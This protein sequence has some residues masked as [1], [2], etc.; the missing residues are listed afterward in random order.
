M[1]AS[2]AEH[3]DHARH[4]EKFLD[5]LIKVVLPSNPRFAD[6]AL[7]VVFYAALHYTKA[8]ILRDHN[9]FAPHHVTHLRGDVPYRGHNDL[10]REHIPAIRTNYR[11]LYELSQEA[12]YRSFFKA[13][14][15][16]VA[17]VRRT[18]QTLDDIKSACGY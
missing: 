9:E 7:V 10:V 4:N 12:R 13:P 16:S 5:H 18:R 8:A 1:A 2:E 17:E 14:G 15:D 11:E 3:L 6:W